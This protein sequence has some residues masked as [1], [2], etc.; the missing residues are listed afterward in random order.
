[1]NTRYINLIQPD[2]PKYEVGTHNTQSYDSPVRATTTPVAP[3]AP[4]R[5]RHKQT[6]TASSSSEDDS[7]RWFPDMNAPSE[8]NASTFAMDINGIPHPN[9]TLF[10]GRNPMF[11]DDDDEDSLFMDLIENEPPEISGTIDKSSL[12][13]FSIKTPAFQAGM[14]EDCVANFTSSM[15]NG[16]K[17]EANKKE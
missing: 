17:E 6:F 13:H 12:H 15:R 3:W 8:Y 4:P 5:I 11:S 10:R 1:M 2:I 14:T 9:I 16:V 7:I